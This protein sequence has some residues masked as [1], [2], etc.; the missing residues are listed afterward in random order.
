MKNLSKFSTIFFV[1]A[2]L[3]AI[4]ASMFTPTTS[5]AQDPLYQRYHPQ[6]KNPIR[7]I[8]ETADHKYKIYDLKG[9]IDDMRWFSNGYVYN[10]EDLAARMEFLK[11]AD[12]K[13]KEYTCD[14]ICVDK[15]Q[16]VVGLNP[17]YAAM[18][19]PR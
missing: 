7:V 14:F 12:V 15:Q 4:I 6:V 9:S 5:Y 8:G 17:A 16:R 10:S 11:P 13:S 18:F 2:F 19:K 3:A 1:I